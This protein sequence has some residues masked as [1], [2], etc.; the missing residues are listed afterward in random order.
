MS[1]RTSCSAQNIA[2]HAGGPLLTRASRWRKTHAK[3]KAITS[4]AADTLLSTY[5]RRRG[6]AEQDSPNPQAPKRMSRERR[7]RLLEN[8]NNLITCQ[9]PMMKKHHAVLLIDSTNSNNLRTKQETTSAGTLIPL[10][11]SP[12][13]SPTITVE[14]QNV[15]PSYI[16]VQGHSG[17]KIQ[18]NF[19]LAADPRVRLY[20]RALPHQKHETAIQE[21]GLALV[22]LDQNKGQQAVHLTLVNPMNTDP[23]KK[24]MAHKPCESHH[25]ATM[26]CGRGRRAQDLKFFQTHTGCVI[27]SDTIQKDYIKEV[28]HIRGRTD[29]NAKIAHSV[30]KVAS[31]KPFD[32]A[33]VIET[34]LARG[35]SVRD[36]SSTHK[37]EIS[38]GNSLYE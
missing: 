35:N 22:G 34:N 20:E 5:E 37:T 12:S 33:K 8:C 11:G 10:G 7:R 9:I 28:I 29:T 19:I 38:E 2:L 15:N 30:N 26:R 17:A 13:C 25:Y 31:G 36:T 21:K 4:F 16:R 27:C 6:I 14:T 1:L 32:E 23:D 3:R 18:T 24:F